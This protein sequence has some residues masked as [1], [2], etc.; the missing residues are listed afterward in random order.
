MKLDVDTKIAHHH[1]M[2]KKIALI[3]GASRGLGAALSVELCV[4]YHIIAVAR[5]TGALEE[6]DDKIKSIGGKA[7][8]APMDICNQDSMAE[9]CKSIFERWGKIDL[10]AHTAIYAAPLAP[11]YSLDSNDWENSIK[12]NVISTG[13]LIPFLTPLMTKRSIALFFRD[14][15]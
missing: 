4:A 5:T 6:L 3:T 12:T 7:T 15:K 13:V 1:L 9:L 8:L 2:K 11:V 14:D 10:W